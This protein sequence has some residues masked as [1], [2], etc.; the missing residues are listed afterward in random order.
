MLCFQHK[1]NRFFTSAE[2]Q[3]RH[4]TRRPRGIEPPSALN[5]FSGP[6]CFALETE[7]TEGQSLEDELQESRDDC[8]EFIVFRQGFDPKEHQ[9]MG[10]LAEER[11]RTQQILREDREWREKE[12]DRAADCH[13]ASMKQARRVSLLTA[14]IGFLAAL[15]AVALGSLLKN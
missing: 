12:A 10:V 5:S 11:A 6:F 3:W 9:Q 8:P 4:S 2:N 13:D 14:L 1:E 7:F 15:A